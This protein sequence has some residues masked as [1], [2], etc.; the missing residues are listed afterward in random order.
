MKTPSADSH[1]PLKP[2]TLPW[3]PD[4]VCHVID[5]QIPFLNEGERFISL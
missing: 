2:L 5:I 4:Y 3:S 1:S